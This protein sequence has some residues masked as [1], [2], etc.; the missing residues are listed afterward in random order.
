MHILR[1]LSEKPFLYLWIGEVLS[2][3]ASYL[4]YFFLILIVFQQTQSNTIVSLMVLS[5]TTPAIFFGVF[6]GIFVDRWNKK[7]V[8]IISTLLRAVLI[9]FLI[10][11]L[12]NLFVVFF[13]SFFVSV[14][15]QFFIPAES[16]MIPLTVR[17]ENLLSANALFGMGL[18]GSM[19]VAYLFLGP[20]ILLLGKV[21]TVAA[22]FFIYLIS[23]FFISLVKVATV[24][25][26]K[27]KV[28]KKT[29][30]SIVADLKHTF[31]VITRTKE[32]AHALFFIAL[33]Q[34]LILILAT[35]APGYANQVIGVS[36]EAFPLL[37]VA[38]AAIGMVFGAILLV[39]VFHSHPK[40]YVITIGLWV[41]GLA[42]LCLPYGSQVAS[43]DFIQVLNQSLPHLFKVTMLHIIVVLAFLL[44][45]ANALVFV[46]ANTL[47]QE[48]TIDEVRGKIYG[49]LN[50]VVGIVSLVPIF[51]VGSLSDLIGV[52]WVIGIIGVGLLLFGI[53]RV[54]IHR[55]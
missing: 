26:Q 54:I 42:M 55:R 51:I 2:Q 48:K 34:V 15:A 45:I 18:F 32:L 39:N 6:A 4:L 1:A 40:Q 12:D 28:F 22:L 11:S 33:A 9:F 38:P 19:L 31:A 3:I 27:V 37:F 21:Q 36:V 13:V 46:P 16:P 30:K 41:S 10:F 43:K 8:L 5:F 53:G 47:I 50:A 23:A 29:T 7:Y 49:L 44:G 14:L 17:R 25:K 35:I 24:K 52:S 20:M